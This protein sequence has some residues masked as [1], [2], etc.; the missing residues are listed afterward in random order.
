M[1]TKNISIT[2]EAYSALLRKKGENDSFSRVIVRELGV[3]DV[4]KLRELFG[5][6]KGKRGKIFEENIL[7]LRNAREKYT[8]ERAKKMKELFV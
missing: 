5:I 1:A 3:N 7:K 4:T 6:M 2:L 8:A